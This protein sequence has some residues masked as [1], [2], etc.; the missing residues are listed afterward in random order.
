MKEQFIPYEQALVLK[1]LGF[2]KGCLAYYLTHGNNKLMPMS[3][4]GLEFILHDSTKAYCSAPLW[5]QAFDWFLQKHQLFGAL[6]PADSSDFVYCIESHKND[7]RDHRVAQSGNF[8]YT[9]A[10]QALL[11]KLIELIK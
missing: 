7:G 3:S 6:Y 11:E 8:P 9:Q 4:S 5:Q 1:E 10:R 2:D